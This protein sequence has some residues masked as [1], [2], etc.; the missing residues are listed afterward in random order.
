[1]NDT[2]SRSITV[3]TRVCFDGRLWEVAEMTAT[4]VVLRDALGGLRQ[5]SISHLLASPGTRLLDTAPAQPALARP[6]TSGL[7]PPETEELRRLTG[8]VRE[9]LTGYQRG[10]E[11]LALPGEPR[12]QYAPGTPKLERCR[13][14]A[15]KLSR[16]AVGGLRRGVT[17]INRRA[18]IGL[19]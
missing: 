17:G 8:H 12:P 5:A 9:V 18:I 2:P 13:A 7:A 10:S 4:G 15:G 19:G 14:K 6:D 1:M 3:R 16:Q 11:A